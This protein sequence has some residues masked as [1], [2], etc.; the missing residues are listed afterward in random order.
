VDVLVNNASVFTGT[1]QESPDGFE[2]MFATNHLGPF[3]LTNLLSEPLRA[4][5]GRVFTI[6][7]PSTTPLDFGD[8]QR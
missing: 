2:L 3:V 7:A 4:A 6:T 5:A 1:R 8:L